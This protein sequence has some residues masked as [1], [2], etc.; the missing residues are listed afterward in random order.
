MSEIQ[1]QSD[2]AVVEERQYARDSAKILLAGYLG[3][4]NLGDDAIVFGLM[5]GLGK[6]NIEIRMLSGF[7]DETYRN[8]KV[9]SVP[10]KDF[11]AI[12][13]EIDKVDA[14]VFPGGSVFQDST[15]WQS[16]LYYQKLVAMAKKAN[17][18]VIMLAQGVGPL[19]SY[20]GK[21]GAVKAFSD[22]DVIAVRDQGSGALLT[23]LGVKKKVHVTGDMAFLLNKPPLGQDATGF[24]VG[25]MKSIGIAP[26]GYGKSK[27]TVQIFGDVCRLLFQNNFLPVLI[28][29]DS[30][31]DGPLIQEIE[32]TQ[33]GKVPSI[34]KIPTPI[35]LQQRMMR[36]EAVIAMRLHAGILAATVE[37]P[38]MMVSY[39]P[40]INAFNQY[41]GLEPPLAF[42]NLTAQR[43]FDN[44]MQ[45][46]KDREKVV[47][48]VATKREE[49]TKLASANIPLLLDSILG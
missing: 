24:Q 31:N 43:L 44:F 1:T 38:A 10:R 15:S 41:M 23:K 5:E 36:M 17:K 37:V 4:G 11:G 14:L 28:E 9:A 25:Q 39:D 7:P 35:Q 34:R 20:F 32:K 12:K 26:R 47:A 40:K 46:Y 16:V 18:K 42:A 2:S 21:T 33:G 45:F 13:S 27:E 19:T 22:A 49:M 6:R 3:C 48:R 8:Y 29:M 30:Q